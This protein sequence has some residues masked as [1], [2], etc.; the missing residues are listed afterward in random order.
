M[1]TYCVKCKKNT[2]NLNS[3]ILKTKKWETNYA[4]NYAMCVEL[5]NLDW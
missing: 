5:K 1:L 2:E 4:I 3:E